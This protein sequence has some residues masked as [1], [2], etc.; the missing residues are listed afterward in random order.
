MRRHYFFMTLLLLLAGSLVSWGAPTFPFEGSGTE[1]SPYLLKTKQD[2]INLSKITS[3]DNT[4]DMSNLSDCAGLYFKMT[5]DIDLEYDES[6]RGI[7]VSSDATVLSRIK[8]KGT[9]DG[10]G[11]A[12]HRL[13][14]N[15]ISWIQPPSQPGAT[16]GRLDPRISREALSFIGHLNTGGTVKNLTMAADCDIVSYRRTGGI[17]GYSY[18]GSTIDNCRNY[19]DVTGYDSFVGGILG[20]GIGE[21][22]NCYNAG[23]ITT[24]L[25]AAGGIAGHC[26]GKIDNC[27]NAGR[28]MS[29]SLSTTA[30]AGS[31][32]LEL[33]GGIAGRINSEVASNCLNVG[34][35]SAV[36]NVGGIGG[37]I[38]APQN[39]LN[40]GIVISNDSTTTGGIGGYYS[41]YAFAPVKPGNCFYDDQIN[42]T[43][44][45]SGAIFAG[46]QGMETSALTNG[47]A[48]E[49]LNNDKWQYDAGMYPVLKTFASEPMLAG[50]RKVIV[51]IKSGEN[52]RAITS[53]ATLS[54]TE[55]LT[56]SLNP[57]AVF[58]IEGN[59]LKMPAQAGE[60]ADTLTGKIGDY[61]KQIPVVFDSDG[62]QKA[63]FE[64]EGTE[65]SPYLLKTKADLI[66]LSKNT[67]ADNSTEAPAKLTYE[68]KYFKLANDIDLEYDEE[69]KGISV[70]SDF[71][72][73]V[74]VQFKG[75]I[76]GDGHSIK[77]MKL[78]RIVWDKSPE[79][80]GEGN[81][82]TV[83]TT[84]SGRVGNYTSFVGC[85]GAGGVVRNLVIDS[86]CKFEGYS[87]I[88]GVAAKMMTGSLIENCR[89]HAD[90]LAYSSLVGGIVGEVGQG[91][92]V[93]SCMNT[94]NVMTGI[95]YC[96]GIAGNCNGTITNCANTGTIT[97]KKITTNIPENQGFF[98]NIG[99]I[100]GNGISPTTLIE[101][102]L[103]AGTIVADREAG[104]IMG[105]F[106]VMNYCLNYGTI[107][108]NNPSLGGNLFGNKANMIGKFVKSL[109]Y[110][111]QINRYRAVSNEDF[112]YNPADGSP[113]VPV[114]IA[115]PTQK[116][117][118]GEALDSLN[119]EYW[120]F[121][122]DM[123]PV[124]KTFANDPVMMAARKVVL[125]LP[126]NENASMA[127]HDMTYRNVAGLEWT[128]SE[129]F[130]VVPSANAISP[131][132]RGQGTITAAY[133]DIAYTKTFFMTVVNA[134][135]VVSVDENLADDPA[136]IFD[137]YTLSGIRVMDRAGKADLKGL[138][139]GIYILKSDRKSV[140]FMVK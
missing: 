38:Y 14:L 34:T 122:K 1:A 36:R 90:I 139:K 105:S 84:E 77:R 86:S 32:K 18:A 69:F 62:T 130:R 27:A 23:T 137:V 138:A 88:A 99:G 117:V 127:N 92:T 128:G 43:N 126:A 48:I 119:A 67:S 64:G 81:L 2:L 87:S 35:V 7:S 63:E 80:A 72:L 140:K 15:G 47:T 103:N 11:H 133:K 98:N 116:L 59:K 91:A 124:L 56:W 55:G 41:G 102:C 5:G 83:N 123:Y 52:A 114:T 39:C 101:N 6:F 82:P 17:V 44:A 74:F 93:R 13:R 95:T 112:V 134:L 8:F 97:G 33:V 107:Y 76:D 121:D 31:T 9:F 45:V 53:E 113:K 111:S 78:G 49:G 37:D 75:V 25:G 132:V 24:G 106:G 136:D 120:Q 96:G 79:E 19:A 26:N 129:Q 68:G 131:I 57:G 65:A 30:A 110:D 10:D 28:V 4:S 50:A 46:M 22:K 3:S 66:L 61:V 16:D 118:S 89:N 21:I 60:K 135:G 58:K 40:Y 20:F 100:S 54:Q 115:V 42:N 73:H 29:T 51:E 108:T 12:I 70:A 85:L 71:R 94:G 109:Y 125:E 104:G